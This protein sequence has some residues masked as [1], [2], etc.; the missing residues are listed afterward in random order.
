MVPLHS[1]IAAGVGCWR[2]RTP[3]E[4]EAA[5]A[6]ALCPCLC[7][8]SL[9]YVVWCRGDVVW[10][11]VVWCG[12]PRLFC[13]RIG[14]DPE[15]IN[16]VQVAML[17]LLRV[18]SSS[19]RCSPAPI[20]SSVRIRTA[21]RCESQVEKFRTGEILGGMH[22]LTGQAEGTRGK[23]KRKRKRKEKKATVRHRGRT[24]PWRTVLC[25]C[26]YCSVGPV[27]SS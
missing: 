8:A 16:L 5:S 22:G 10:S 12:V 4:Q 18:S 2:R 19:A 21:V 9:R 27:P 6:A 11:C 17:A 24:V 3:A 14:L 20:R 15:C 13:C 7:A 25:C 1:T 23:A 26:R